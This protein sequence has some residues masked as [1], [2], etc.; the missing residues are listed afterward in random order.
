MVGVA[1]AYYAASGHLTT[2]AVNITDQF[3]KGLYQ[4][5]V[6]IGLMVSWHQVHTIG[7]SG[8][9]RKRPQLLLFYG[10][11]HTRTRGIKVMNVF[12]RILLYAHRQWY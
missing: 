11:C 2:L 9:P 4:R 12:C 3:H 6:D 7:D 1:I 10:I 5:L 8:L